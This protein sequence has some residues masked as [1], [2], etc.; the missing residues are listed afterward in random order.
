MLRTRWSCS[1]AALTALCAANG[2][3]SAAARAPRPEAG[4]PRAEVLLGPGATAPRPAAS[5]RSWAPALGARLNS[6]LAIPLGLRL[7]ERPELV[8]L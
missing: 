3:P 5:V 8:R 4:V 1:A 2:P 7:D 6:A